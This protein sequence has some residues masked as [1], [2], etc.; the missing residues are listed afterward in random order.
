MSFLILTLVGLVIF[1]PLYFWG[2]KAIGIFLGGK[3]ES[4]DIYL[5]IL[6]PMFFIRFVA[7]PLGHTLNAFERQE[8]N[9]LWQVLLLFSV[10]GI[11]TFS[12][13]FQFS[14]TESLVLYSIGVSTMYIIQVVMDFRVAFF[15][16]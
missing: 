8:L 15:R 16:R 1:V 3:V 5:K 2:Q 10:I 9:M 14:L 7:N 6:I 4:I 13:I 12:N 11:F